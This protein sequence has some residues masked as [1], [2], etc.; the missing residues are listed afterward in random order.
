MA[1]V[2]GILGAEWVLFVALAWYL[3]QVFASGTG[4]RR[5]PL[6]FLDPCRKAR[7]GRRAGRGAGRPGAGAGAGARLRGRA[8]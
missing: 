8:R 3:E 1:A 6:Y 2:W 7:N 5:H 4:N